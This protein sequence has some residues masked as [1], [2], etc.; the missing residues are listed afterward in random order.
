[1]KFSFDCEEWMSIKLLNIKYK[2]LILDSSKNLLMYCLAMTLLFVGS[3]EAIEEA[4]ISSIEVNHERNWYNPQLSREENFKTLIELANKSPTGAKIIEEAQL[5]ASKQGQTLM[6]ILLVGEG[7]L[8]DTTL[9]RR[10][11][12]HDP[13]IIDYEL[14]SKVQ[15]SRHAKLLDAVLDFTHELTHYSFREAFNPYSTQFSHPEFLKSTVEGVGGEVDAYL[16][17]CKVLK[18][19]L[20][21]QFLSR[22]QCF[23][24]FDKTNNEFSKEL[25]KQE[26]YKVGP[27]LKEVEKDLD[28]F[29]KDDLLINEVKSKMSPSGPTFL[30]SAWQMPYPLAA[31][32]EYKNIMSKVCKNDF[33]RMGFLKE[34]IERFPASV[35]EKQQRE[36]SLII[37][38]DYKKRCEFFSKNS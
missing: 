32:F 16:V 24:V 38:E 8:T 20:P 12:A 5:K 29:S 31:S 25:A 9:V 6:D 13:T 33:N 28:L 34:K 1:M 17:E 21:K 4:T 15:I 7:S 37:F 19:L 11:K 3:L 36:R 18:E 26:F 22:S 14:K 23:R 10:F 30:S 27:H 2:F 35:E